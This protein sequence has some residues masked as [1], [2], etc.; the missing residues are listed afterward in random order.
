MALPVNLTLEQLQPSDE[1]SKKLLEYVSLT[2]NQMAARPLTQ[3]EQNKVFAVANHMVSQ[4]ALLA[5]LDA[6]LSD[7]VI[8]TAFRTA[9]F[10]FVQGRERFQKAVAV[11]AAE[12][13]TATPAQGLEQKAC[14]FCSTPVEVPKELDKPGRLYF[15][16]ERCRMNWQKPL[17]SHQ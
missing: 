1:E 17:Q 3:E 12:Q 11:G 13:G 10:L 14:A 7:E 6:T 9:E 2:F 15:C 4:L 5:V 16:G 8:R